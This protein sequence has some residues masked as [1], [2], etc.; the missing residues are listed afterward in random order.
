MGKQLRENTILK[1]LYEEDSSIVV[2]RKARNVIN[3]LKH[4][5]VNLNNNFPGI[6]YDLIPSLNKRGRENSGVGDD[7]NESDEE[8]ILE[9]DNFE[10]DEGK[11]RIYFFYIH[12]CR[13]VI[14]VDIF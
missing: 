12:N 9:G 6:A 14:V 2:A 7:F 4:D 5:I 10:E 13:C 8:D 1:S 11:N 3:F